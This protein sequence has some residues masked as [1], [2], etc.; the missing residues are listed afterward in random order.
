MSRCTP[1]TL[2]NMK[3]IRAGE[4]SHSNMCFLTKL[5]FTVVVHGEKF[6]F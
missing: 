4:N 3:A 2:N 6:T 1:V 5:D